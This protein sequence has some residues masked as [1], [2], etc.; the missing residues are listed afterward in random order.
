MRVLVLGASL[1]PERISFQAIQMLESYDHEVLAV[2]LRAGQVGT[3]DILTNQLDFDNID[4]VTL[5]LNPA[6]QKPY[7][8]Y[9]IKRIQPKKVI[10]NPGTENPEF[11]KDLLTHGIQFEEACT[12]VLLRT[13]QFNLN[14]I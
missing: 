1:K 2:G 12:L 11:Q 9:I 5:Y 6:N 10:F 3:T 4:I 13:N 7:Y 8:D 14:A